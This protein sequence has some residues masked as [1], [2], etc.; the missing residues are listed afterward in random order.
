[1]L[2]LPGSCNFEDRH[3]SA[4]STTNTQ[5]WSG[6]AIIPVTAGGYWQG[7]SGTTPAPEDEEEGTRWNG[8]DI[9]PPWAGGYYLSGAQGQPAWN[10]HD[11][12][13]ADDEHQVRIRYG[14]WPGN[15]SSGRSMGQDD[16]EGTRGRGNEDTRD[17]RRV[18]PDDLEDELVGIFSLRSCG[19]LSYSRH[20]TVSWTTLSFRTC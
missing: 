5:A 1:M 9:I 20:R 6:F 17:E 15:N 10:G 7:G 18:E 3:H 11:I 8:F 13:G 16:D 12:P 2:D 19:S 14:M 4:G